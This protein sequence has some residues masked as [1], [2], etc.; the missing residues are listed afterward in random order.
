MVL[1]QPALTLAAWTAEINKMRTAYGVPIGEG[2]IGALSAYLAKVSTSQ[3]S[4]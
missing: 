1:K 3:Q 2:E 4:H